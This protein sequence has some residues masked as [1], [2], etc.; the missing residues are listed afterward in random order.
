MPAVAEPTIVGAASAT[1]APVPAGGKEIFVSQIPAPAAPPAPPAPGSAKSK[2]IETLKSRAKPEPSANGEPPA[3]T[4]PHAKESAKEPE[5]PPVSEPVTPPT[6]EP[7]ATEADKKK[8][9]PWKLVDEY[10]A[11]VAKAEA[12]K[13]ELSKRAIPQDKWEETQKRLEAESKRNQE[14]EEHIK[15]VDYSKSN[16]FKEKYQAPYDAA[17]KRA[18]GELGEL[19]VETEDGN[20]ALA[21]ADLLELVN[22]TLPEARARAEQVFGSFANDVMQHRKEIRSLF[23]Q[24]NAALESA[25]KGSLEREKQML[26]QSE[27]QRTEVL[28]ELKE[29]WT[30]ANESALADEK[31]GKFFKPEEGDEQGNQRLAKGFELADRSFAEDPFAKGLTPEQ[32]R[33]ITQRKAAVRNRCAAFGKLH[34]LNSQLEQKVATLAKELEQYKASSPSTGGRASPAPNSKPGGFASLADELRK[35]AK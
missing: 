1:P 35:R 8:V 4:S 31:Y 10:K 25:K 20:R 28:S 15:F 26:E 30:K 16:E 32:R 14:L 11:K 18:M 9:N 34:H 3:L 13:L 5:K 33:E 22:M 19:T 29:V 23:D 27:R 21:P 2:M 17:W 12:E 7:T 6:E 24:Q